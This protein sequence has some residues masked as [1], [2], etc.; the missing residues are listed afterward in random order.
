VTTALDGTGNT[1]F[2]SVEADVAQ[3]RTTNV[4]TT[5]AIAYQ[6][7]N[8]AGG[9]RTL[10]TIATDSNGVTLETDYGSNNGLVTVLPETG[11]TTFSNDGAL[12]YKETDPG[13]N[14][15]G[16]TTTNVVNADGT[17]ARTTNTIDGFGNPQQDV[18]TQTATLTGQYLIHELAGPGTAGRAFTFTAPAGSTPPT[19]GYY[20]LTAAGALGSQRAQ[21]QPGFN[22]LAGVTSLVSETDT[23][24]ANQALD[25]SCAPAAAYNKNST[26]V[27][28]VFTTIDV[29]F[30][31]YETRTTSSYDQQG[32]GTVCTVVSDTIQN[33][34]DYSQQ[35]GNIRLFPA[36]TSPTPVAVVQINESLSLQSVTTPS[37]TARSA[38]SVGGGFI[39]PHSLVV[40]RVEHAVHQNAMKRLLSLRKAGGN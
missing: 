40:S 24:T 14:P 26:L 13:I 33:F 6:T 28:Q 36:Q 23:I 15:A 19:I 16:V 18:S 37:S 27:K 12:T 30:G 32:P 10:S 9:V 39:L 20:N 2:T 31:T 8:G 17:Y 35:L 22:W 29:V 34:Y 3:L 25:P 38:Q 4:T 11:G 5:A 1:V 7:V 21:T